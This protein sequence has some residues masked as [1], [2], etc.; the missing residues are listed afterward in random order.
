MEIPST[1]LLSSR[2]TLVSGI[3][4][5][6]LV[7]ASQSAHTMDLP[8]SFITHHTVSIILLTS[9]QSANTSCTFD[10]LMTIL[11]A[12]LMLRSY[13]FFEFCWPFHP[14]LRST[15]FTLPHGLF[16][17]IWHVTLIMSPQGMS[18]GVIVDTVKPV[19]VVGP[20][21]HRHAHP[22]AEGQAPLIFYIVKGALYG[23][24]SSSLLPAHYESLI[25]RGWRR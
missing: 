23:A 4:C 21:L 10:W 6:S 7:D 3:Q 12:L 20:F 16:M 8:M 25:N 24:Q 1:L 17:D 9:G 14:I 2:L 5:R 13:F 15:S 11:I 19:P 22:R 18:E